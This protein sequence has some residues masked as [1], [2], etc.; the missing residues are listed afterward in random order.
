MDQRIF[1][2]LK[3]ARLSHRRMIWLLPHFISP[4]P[5]AVNKLSQSS[6]VSPFELTGGRWERKV[7]EPNNTTARKPGPL[8]IIQYSLKWTVV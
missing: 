4:L 3:R 7:E 6:C 1:N 5:L 8:L 2:D